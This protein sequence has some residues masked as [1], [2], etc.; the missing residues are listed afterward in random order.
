MKLYLLILLLSIPFVNGSTDESYYP[1]IDGFFYYNQ[2]CEWV[3]SSSYITKVGENHYS[4]FEFD[5]SDIPR[6]SDITNVVFTIYIN[7]YEGNPPHNIEIY[8]RPFN[9]NG[10]LDCSDFFDNGLNLGSIDIWSS[11]SIDLTIPKETINKDGKTTIMIKSQDGITNIRTSEYSGTSSD[12]RLEISY[13][14]KEYKDTRKTRRFS[15]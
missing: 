6:N 10:V 2:G 1:D 11:G 3:D 8:Y 4:I 12:P 5:T 7:N 14:M 9:L 13:E 15:I